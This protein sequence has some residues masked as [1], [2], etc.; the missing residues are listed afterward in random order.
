MCGVVAFTGREEAAPVLLEG[1]RRPEYRGYDTAGVAIVNGSR[2][3]VRKTEGRLEM[4][5]R[6]LEQQPVPGFTGIGHTRWATHGRPAAHN[7]HPHLDCTGRVAVVHNGIIENFRA[8]RQELSGRGHRFLSETD[9]EVLAHL[10]EENYQGDLLAAVRAAVARLEGSW[11]IAAVHAAEP[12]RIV[13]ARRDSPLVVGL[14]EGANYAAS[15]I[16]ALLSY[17]RSVYVLED[18]ELGVIAPD[19]VRI[20]DCQGRPAPKRVWRV[21]WDA[22]A[23]EK[24]GWPH[25]MLKEIHEQPQAIRDTLA[26]RLDR[27]RGRILLPELEPDSAFLRHVQRVHVVG[28]GTARHAGLAG[29]TF[30]ERFARVPAE[31][32]WAAEYRYREPLVDEDTLAVV[33][34]QSGETADTLAALRE[35]RARGARVLAVT[36]VVGSSVAREADHVLY[37]RAGPEV[38]VASTKA[39]T[40]QL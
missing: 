6:L 28:M 16:P 9:T 2:L 24:G 30:L 37:T 34:S 14:G 3:A 17:T 20:V 5:A 11:A 8:L 23:A 1:L 31:V 36:N 15:D 4:L 12:D 40:T 32:D 26:G 38:A 29:Q 19:G 22:A 21:E 13:V 7:A 18:G 10:I 25:F 33:I 39:Y 27:E 35:A